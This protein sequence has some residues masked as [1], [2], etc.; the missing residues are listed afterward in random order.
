M[1]VY[2]D[3]TEEARINKFILHIRTEAGI[4]KRKTFDQVKFKK[5]NIFSIKKK[6]R[7]KSKIKKP[8]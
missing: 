6:V 2:D 4:Y 7:F 1:Y 3:E 5:K 8:R